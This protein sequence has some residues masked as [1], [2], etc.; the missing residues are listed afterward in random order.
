MCLLNY[1]FHLELLDEIV[2]AWR[3]GPQTHTA[4]I[5]A[6]RHQVR[7]V[8]GGHG[9]HPASRRL[10]T[11]RVVTI[12]AMVDAVAAAANA[13]GVSDGEDGLLLHDR[14]EGERAVVGAAH[15]ALLVDHAH[16]VDRVTISSN[17]MQCL[18]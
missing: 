16:A 13:V 8:I 14:P 9:C 5:R 10:V 17:K 1:E 18:N 2:R 4:V 12:L 7:V 6:A 3:K 15:E 11:T